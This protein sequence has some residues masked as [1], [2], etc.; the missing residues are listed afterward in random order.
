[1][2]VTGKLALVIAL[3]M[4]TSHAKGILAT[5]WENNGATWFTV[6]VGVSLTLIARGS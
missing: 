6:L 5:A 4:T 3:V 2:H 1:M